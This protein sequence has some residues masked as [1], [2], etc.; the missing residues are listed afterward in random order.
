MIIKRIL[1]GLGGT[2]F[3]TV[4][5]RRS[6][7]LAKSHDAQLTGV[8]VVDVNRLAHVG[9]V[10]LGGSASA[11]ALREHRLSVTRERV[12]TAIAELESACREAGI[13]VRILREQG[14]PFDLMMSCSRYHDVTVF[15][16]RSIFEYGV[17]GEIEYDPGDIL[18]RLIAG[19][20]RP[21]VAVSERYRPIRRVLIA[22][23]G[24]MISAET[25]R[26]LVQ[27]GPWPD[28]ALR[29]VAFQH[30]EDEAK[31]LLANAAEYCRAHGF[32]PEVGHISGSPKDRLLPEAD[33]WQA[34]LICVGSGA[35]SLLLGRLFGDTALQL[36]RNADRPLFLAQ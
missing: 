18:T 4:A 17:L 16:L 5:I 15:G 11:R 9:P 10:P 21:I 12:E 33:S 13:S 6:V 28:A 7:E 26:R 20:V 30:P 36:I 24:S 22:Y 35:R 31:A 23:S 29:I 1:V 19:G 27:L 34:D 25:M 32:E 8:S 14:D 2:P 3:T